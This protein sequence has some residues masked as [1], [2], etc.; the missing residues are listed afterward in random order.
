VSVVSDRSQPTGRLAP[1]VAP[2][3]FYGEDERAAADAVL[4]SGHVNYWT[5]REGREFERE[6]AAHLGVRHAIALANGTLALELA[7]RCWG[8][9][10]GDEVVVTP[11]SFM[12]SVSCVV[13]Q[14]ATP[15]FAD[16]DRDSG[17]LTAQSI[18]RVITA[19]TRA[20]IPVHL[21]GWPCDMGP[22]MD[23][24]RSR[25]LKVL[26]DCAQAHGARQ[27]GTAVG[28]LG[29]AAAFSFC[30][31]KII[32]T[33][34]EGGM[35]ATDDETLWRS[36]WSFKDHGKD[37]DAVYDRQ[38]PPGY[39]WVH[40]SFGTNWRL[41]EPQ[42]AI[43]RRQL[44]KLADW[45]A[46]RARNAACYIEA[47]APLSA[48]RVPVPPPGIEHA[49]YK[50][51]SYVRPEALKQGWS[52]DR[53]M[54]EINELG[55]PC[56]AGSCSELYLEKAFEGS[57][58]R[59]AQRLAVARELGETSLMFLVHPTVSPKDAGRMARIAADVVRAATR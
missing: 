48:L 6:Y 11:R 25:G 5:G 23:L 12:A 43:G 17:N 26:E 53:L 40:E 58:F 36:A 18:E 10:P 54:I 50:F 39:R 20:V 7:L 41:T 51:Y 47:F 2:W 34:G 42:A 37:W 9:G 31:D 38:H 52:R 44:T 30:Q 49:W 28:A 21:A 55:V 45:H 4:A 14:G 15:V 22:I 33:A 57:G 13:L 56:F 27:H 1:V 24:A 16:V 59:P 8:V 29:H 32:T 3:P 19:R 35:L 46:A